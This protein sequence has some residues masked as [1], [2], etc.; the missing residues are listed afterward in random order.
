[1]PYNTE[2]LAS[3]VTSNTLE[4]FTP[5]FVEFYEKKDL[6][7]LFSVFHTAKSFE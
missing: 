6:Y 5:R 3:M 4:Y 1:M 7:K 2:Q